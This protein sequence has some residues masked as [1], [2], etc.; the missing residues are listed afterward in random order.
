MKNLLVKGSSRRGGSGEEVGWGPLGR[1]GVE[2]GRPTKTPAKVIPS[3]P[4]RGSHPRFTY[5]KWGTCIVG[6][7]LAVNLGVACRLASPMGSS[8][9]SPITILSTT[10]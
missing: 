6:L 4:R 5:V 10:A 7:T 3:L 1:P 9:C 8:P 2:R